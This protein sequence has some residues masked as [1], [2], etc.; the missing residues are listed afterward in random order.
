MP[1]HDTLRERQP[2]STV[3]PTCSSPT[4]LMLF[5]CGAS[6]SFF[7]S[8]TAYAL[9]ADIPNNPGRAADDKRMIGDIVR[10]N[11]AGANQRPSPHRYPGDNNGA[12]ANRGPT[13]YECS[14]DNPIACAFKRAIGVNRARHAIIG[15]IT[16]GPTNTPSSISSP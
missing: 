10:H 7:L 3:L 11:R 14:P 1:A 4:R 15:K 13:A 16:C 2:D 6:N 5:R 9:R 12:G 8:H